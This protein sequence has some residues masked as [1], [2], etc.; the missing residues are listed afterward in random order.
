MREEDLPILRGLWLGR[1]PGSYSSSFRLQG[2]TGAMTLEKLVAT[3]RLFAAGAA[4]SMHP[5]TRCLVRSGPERDAQ[6]VWQAHPDARVRPVLQA[7]PA[8]TLLLT[9]TQPNWYVDAHAG[10]AGI[11]VMP[12][13]A[14]QLEDLLSMPAITPSPTA[15]S[16]YGTSAG[17]IVPNAVAMA[18]LFQSTFP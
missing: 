5:G 14:E 3:D 11:L 17:N 15:I 10:E 1:A 9:T 7:T 13:P 18:T 12:W 2:A 16:A 4:S 6:L 8:A